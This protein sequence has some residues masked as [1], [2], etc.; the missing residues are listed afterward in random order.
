MPIGI[1]IL[2]YLV[3]D[4]LIVG[5]AVIALSSRKLAEHAGQ[6]LKLMSRVV[7]A[8]GWESA[9]SLTRIIGVVAL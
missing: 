4:A 6:L 8:I 7:N 2:G 5:A 3:D 9:A 1:Y